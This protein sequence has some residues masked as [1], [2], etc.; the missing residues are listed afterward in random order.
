[1]T[2]VAQRALTWGHPFARWQRPLAVGLTILFLT[3]GA[4]LAVTIWNGASMR[5]WLWLDG[6]F[7][8]GLGRH[9][10]ETGEMYFP[11]Q[12]AG[13]YPPEGMVNLYPPIA[14]YLFVP[15]AILPL[16]LWWI[17]PLG[18]VAWHVW[19]CRPAWWTWPILALI[20]ALVPT[21]VAVLW[22]N[23]VIWSAALV[24]LAC[25]W[26]AFGPL[27][28]FK[29]TDLVAVVV[30]VRHRSFWVGV[31]VVIGASLILLPYWPLWIQATSNIAGS[32][33]TRNVHNLPVA[34]FPLVVWWGRTRRSPASFRAR[35]EP[36]RSW[37]MTAGRRTTPS[38]SGSA[39]RRQT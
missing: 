4:V 12:F 7:Y 9:F 5:G 1:M 15:A 18:I 36:A 27:V 3:C 23:T 28:A 16:P 26:P 20:A 21:I 31:A 8:A 32:G 38:H 11:L 17:V 33:F 2:A 39:A 37:A 19:D 25:R 14:M 30:F 13:P 24:A 35:T 22:G 34:L 6:Q 10:L 29:P